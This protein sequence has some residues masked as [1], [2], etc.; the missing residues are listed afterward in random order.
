MCQTIQE[1]KETVWCLCRLWDLWRPWRLPV[2]PVE[3]VKMGQEIVCY[4][5]LKL[6][7]PHLCASVQCGI[8]RASQLAGVFLWI[9]SINAWK[10]LHTSSLG[11]RTSRLKH[12]KPHTL[13][14]R[15]KLQAS[16]PETVPHTESSSTQTAK[17]SQ[18]FSDDYEKLLRDSYRQFDCE[19]AT[20]LWLR[21]GPEQA[22]ACFALR[23]GN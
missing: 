3:L 19:A 4:L 15:P 6:E 9:P 8:Q 12:W 17:Y 23:E 14:A 2:M 21:I 16:E 1:E 5:V 13:L 20:T 11:L 10:A 7:I 22:A 18:H